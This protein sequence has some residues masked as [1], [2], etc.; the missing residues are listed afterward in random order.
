[1]TPDTNPPPQPDRTAVASTPASAE[2]APAIKT[3]NPA[4][5]RYGIRPGQVYERADGSPGRVIVRDVFS[6]EEVDD[7]I[8]Y[9]EA[10]GTEYRIDAFKLAKVRYCLAVV[11]T[12][13]ERHALMLALQTGTASPE[14]QRRA[15]EMLRAQQ[16]RI[17]SLEADARRGRHAVKYG[18]W[19]RHEDEIDGR[20][21]WLAVRVA[22]R[23]DLSCEAMRAN[24]LDLAIEEQARTERER[25]F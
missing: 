23:A 4:H 5:I 16:E 13:E 25:G 21:T 17:A 14:D 10:R 1:M 6:L 22:G 3:R 2:Q 11:S 12:A 9:D 7:V 8:V 18:E 19:R 20:M 15:G 24:A